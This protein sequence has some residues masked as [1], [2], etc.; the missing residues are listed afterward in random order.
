MAGAE[1]ATVGSGPLRERFA[2]DKRT[3]VP[4]G[5]GNTEGEWEEQFVVAARRESLKGGE[6]VMAARLEKRQPYIVTIRY[7]ENTRRITHDW[8]A[9]DV[10]T[11]AE[12]NLTSVVARPKRDY[13]DILLTEGQAA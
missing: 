11:D 4:D 10:R 5:A 12:Y 9:R 2:F 3:D 6:T 1:R 7:N 8:R 13:I